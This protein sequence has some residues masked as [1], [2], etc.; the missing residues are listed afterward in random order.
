MT[1][2]K[3]IIMALVNCSTDR[4]DH[5]HYDILIDP[6]RFKAD[7]LVSKAI[8]LKL[9][10]IDNEDEEINNL[11]ATVAETGVYSCYGDLKTRVA[12][13]SIAAD[14]S[15]ISEYER[16]KFFCEKY[17][18]SQPIFIKEPSLWSHVR[19]EEL[20]NTGPYNI[21]GD[22]Q[23]LRTPTALYRIIWMHYRQTELW[24]YLKSN[25][26]NAPLY[27]RI[28]PYDISENELV[29][30][31]EETIQPIDPKFWQKIKIYKEK[32]LRHTFFK[33]TAKDGIQTQ[34]MLLIIIE[35]T[36]D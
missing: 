22:G 19:D 27:L 30:L 11:R 23:I 10:S 21:E 34:L 3:G 1:Q 28:N 36:G 13:L 2:Y 32:N 35:V 25:F 31:Y 29:A 7:K 18:K 16:D 26:S 14:I 12:V 17:N 5:F 8:E 33:T 6:H 24:E 20:I 9:L 15:N 4:S